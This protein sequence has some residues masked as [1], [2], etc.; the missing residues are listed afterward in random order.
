MLIGDVFDAV[1]KPL[2]EFR[3]AGLNLAVD[4][5]GRKIGAQFQSAEKKGIHYAL[6]IGQAEIDS[7]QYTVKNLHSGEEEKHGVDRIVSVVKD[8][9]HQDE[10]ND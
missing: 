7:G 6:I 2:A 5:S 10:D 3:K 9:R 4:V 1:Q 8:R